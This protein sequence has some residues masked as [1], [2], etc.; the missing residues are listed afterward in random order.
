MYNIMRSFFVLDVLVINERVPRAR[1]AL[2]AKVRLGSSFSWAKLYIQ[3]LFN[4]NICTKDSIRIVVALTYHI[5]RT[6]VGI[7][8][9]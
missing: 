6:S 2:I 3:H 9:A 4:R 1:K 7:S 5:C 8:Q